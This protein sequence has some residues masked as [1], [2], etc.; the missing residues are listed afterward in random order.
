M[1]IVFYVIL[2]VGSTLLSQPPDKIGFMFWFDIMR[3][4]RQ[5]IAVLR[6]AVTS[7]TVTFPIDNERHETLRD[8][9]IITVSGWL[10]L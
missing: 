1:L 3:R 9:I 8:S 7:F 4:Y 10:S 6:E 5:Y 2:P